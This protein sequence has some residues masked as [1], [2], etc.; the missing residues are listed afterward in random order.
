VDFGRGIVSTNVTTIRRWQTATNADGLFEIDASGLE[1]VPQYV[2]F[3]IESAMADGYAEGSGGYSLGAGAAVRGERIPKIKLAKGRRVS[4]R[5]V[6]P[7]GQPPQNALVRAAGSGG[8]SNVWFPSPRKCAA[9]GTFE[10]YVALDMDVEFVAHADG[11]APNR[12][13]VAPDQAQTGDIVVQRGTTLT[14]RVLNANGA[15]VADTIV[16]LESVQAGE[17][18]QVSFGTTFAAKT[19]RAGEFRLPPMAGACKIWV[20]KTIYPSNQLHR[21]AWQTA[22]IPPPIAPRIIQLDPNVAEQ[23]VELRGSPT[24]HFA[25]TVRWPDGT[26]VSGVEVI[27]GVMLEDGGSGINLSETV[28]NEH[29]QYSFELPNPLSGATI[30]VFGSK[31]AQGKWHMAYPATTVAAKQKSAQFL[32]FTRLDS[33]VANADWELKQYE[34][35]PAPKPMSKVELE[36]AKISERYQAH[37]EKYL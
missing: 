27:A 9:D 8:I 25:G 20:T 18:K 5:V 24:L 6:T 19:N 35:P 15:P 7:D 23:S 22:V 2:H 4:G 36:M 28:T 11:F 3:R 26:P 21:D 14:G 10:I 32:V 34:A 16:A 37:Q 30:N 12:V 31:D 29:G 1:P 17:L 13:T 33:D